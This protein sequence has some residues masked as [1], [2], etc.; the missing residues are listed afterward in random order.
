MIVFTA[1]V[2]DNKIYTFSGSLTSI[3]PNI[4]PTSEVYC[5][6]PSLVSVETPNN[7]I[8]KEFVLNQNYPNPFN[9]STKIQYSVPQISNVSIKIFDILG[10]DIETLVNKEKPAG[11][12]ELTWNAVNLPGGVYFYQLRAVDH[13]TSSGQ[14]FIQTNKMILLK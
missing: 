10:N 3:M 13:S 7:H 11:T 6:D 9:P 4:T 5:F 1:S 2:F 8:P 14:V 12:Y